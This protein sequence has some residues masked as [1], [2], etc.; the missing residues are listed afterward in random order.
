MTTQG[1]PEVPKGSL[2]SSPKRTWLIMLFFGT[3]MAVA[4]VYLSNVLINAPNLD[5]GWQDLEVLPLDFGTLLGLYGILATL[6]VALAFTKS[7]RLKD[8]ATITESLRHEVQKNEIIMVATLLVSLASVMWA[9]L[10]TLGLLY[11]A[12][13]GEDRT[14]LTVGNISEI[15]AVF[16]LAIM[17]T[18]MGSLVSPTPEA[19]M[20]QQLVHLDDTEAKFAK[21][22]SDA[23][24]TLGVV[25]VQ[26]G[27][28]Q[29]WHLAVALL[30]WPLVIG[31]LAAAAVA[32]LW[33]GHPQPSW[34]M[35]PLIVMV[36][37]QLLAWS[38][39]LAA[40]SGRLW[41]FAVI[42][43]L[44]VAFGLFVLVDFVTVLQDLGGDPA[45]AARAMTS[46][47]ITTVAFLIV[48][49][50]WILQRNPARPGTRALWTQH[51]YHARF[52]ASWHA[53]TSRKQ[54]LQLMEDHMQRE[55]RR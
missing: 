51:V 31:G 9:G 50:P 54:H 24:A 18:L 21:L 32:L 15:A 55:P 2:L 3:V 52:F 41:S 28:G 8:G 27:Y 49:V 17:L 38:L 33:A 44:G 19:L 40:A 42:R 25:P 13:A 34:V 35:T 5:I 4:F 14:P 22:E 16:F 46:L 26:L 45:L 53:L 29:Q 47:T 1:A 36:F 7:P 48:V 12:F 10:F 6:V 30:A 11:Q 43:W 23:A 39:V 20:V 37:F